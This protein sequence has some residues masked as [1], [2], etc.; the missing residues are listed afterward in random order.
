M[1]MMMMMKGR[2]GVIGLLRNAAKDFL[3]YTY[4]QHYCYV[5]L[6]GVQSSGQWAERRGQRAESREQKAER[7]RYILEHDLVSSVDLSCL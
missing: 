3:F 4:S 5:V 6:C 7:Q 1:T 2:E